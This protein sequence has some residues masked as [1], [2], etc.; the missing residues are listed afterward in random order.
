M[1]NSSKAT[2]G[3]FGEIRANIDIGK[4]NAYLAEN[5]SA[6]KAPVEVKQFKASKHCVDT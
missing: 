6:V 2:G 4:L 5:V 1:S 3:G